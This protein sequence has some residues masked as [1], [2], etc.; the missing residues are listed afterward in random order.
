MELEYPLVT[1]IAQQLV[2][3]LQCSIQY[4]T[5][6]IRAAQ[7]GWSI[8]AEHF[9]R[10][11]EEEM[12][13]F[14]AIR[15]FLDRRRARYSLGELAINSTEFTTVR[16]ALD[17]QKQLERQATEALK[18]LHKLCHDYRDVPATRLCDDLLLSQVDSEDR[19]Q[20]MIDIYM[21]I[22]GGDDSTF[23]RYLELQRLA[24]LTKASL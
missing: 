3:E 13:H 20:E 24:R 2:Q 15:S 9:D 11:A 7:L 1:Q 16:E 21:G 6:S 19:A 8:L 18:T 4:R 17:L 10:E 22:A 14:S 12:E 23:L 5:M